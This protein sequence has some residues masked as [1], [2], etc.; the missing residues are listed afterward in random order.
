MRVLSGIQSSGK[1]HLG[2]YFG[3]MAKHIALQEQ[4]ECFYFIANLAKKFDSYT[5]KIWWLYCYSIRN[6]NIEIN[7]LS[8]TLQLDVESLPYFDSFCHITRPMTALDSG[9]KVYIFSVL[10]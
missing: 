4:H 2:N 10:L 9:A 1:L 6:W 8:F 3:A 5:Y 7:F